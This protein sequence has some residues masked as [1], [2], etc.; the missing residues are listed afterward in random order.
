MS[1]GI[2]AITLQTF[3]CVPDVNSVNSVIDARYC[4]SGQNER[5]CLKAVDHWI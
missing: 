2:Q 4:L 1:A 5:R 3:K